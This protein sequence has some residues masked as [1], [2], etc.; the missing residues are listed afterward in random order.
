MASHIYKLGVHK[1]KEVEK[2]A[3]FFEN[4]PKYTKWT[5][6]MKISAAFWTLAVPYAL[7]K[8]MLPSYVRT[9]QAL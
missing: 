9:L 2:M 7:W 5:P 4:T 8:L 6:R 1:E 3:N